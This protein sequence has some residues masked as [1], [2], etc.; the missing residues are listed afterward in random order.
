MDF[1]TFEKGDT[2]FHF[3]SYEQA[4]KRL[5]EKGKGPGRIFRTYLNIQKPLYVSSDIG[6]WDALPFAMYLHGEQVLTDAEFADV[7][8]LWKTDTGYD[9]DAAV[10]LREILTEKGY[11][12]LVYPNSFEGQGD[13][14]MVFRDDQSIRSEITKFGLEG[15][16]HQHSEALPSAVEAD[17]TKWGDL[18]IG[19]SLSAKAKNYQVYDPRSGEY[20]TFAEGSQI[21][22]PKVFAGKGGVKPLR[23]EVIEGL[24]REY[25]T[26]KPSN[27]QHCKGIA[28]INFYGEERAA[29]VHW[30]QEE[31][32]GKHK[33][34][35]KKWIE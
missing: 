5:S 35:I 15:T 27:W 18:T 9:S 26:D 32:V 31:T 22:N 6:R 10:R 2:G 24:T 14:Y 34:K 7:C 12:G 1:T 33:F 4:T 3:G 17:E 28:T 25:S 8:N 19:K 23:P 16:K 21:R 11:D 30:F 29:E 20:F 13:S